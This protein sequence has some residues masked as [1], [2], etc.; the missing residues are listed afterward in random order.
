MAI[1][2]RDVANRVE[3]DRE[4]VN[5][6]VELRTPTVLGQA[7]TPH[8]FRTHLGMPSDLFGHGQMNVKRKAKAKANVKA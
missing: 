4:L 1:A 7:R 8:R 6:L 2:V 5:L 3:L